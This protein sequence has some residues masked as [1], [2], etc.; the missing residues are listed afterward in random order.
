MTSATKSP[1]S[2]PRLIG[3]GGCWASTFPGMDTSVNNVNKE[4][5]VHNVQELR[6]WCIFFY[7][8]TSPSH[9][10]CDKD[11]DSWLSQRRLPKLKISKKT[12]LSCD[13][14]YSMS[15]L[16][17]IKWLYMPLSITYASE[18]KWKKLC[19]K[20]GDLITLLFSSSISRCNMY[21]QCN[22]T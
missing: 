13:T 19:K 9:T 3:R 10:K 2:N 16:F 1:K 11:T 21:T 18:V 15:A 8:S 17:S 6:L 14:L 4:K 20:P 22:I 5:I 7:S 12:A